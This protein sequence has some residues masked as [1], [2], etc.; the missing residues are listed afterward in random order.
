MTP[1]HPFTV[2]RRA[3]MIAPLA[4]GATAL[5]AR[6]RQATPSPGASP[7]PGDATVFGELDGQPVEMYT[8]S[9]ANGMRITVLTYGGTIQSITVPDKD[10]NA[11]N[12]ALGFDNLD[13]Y[14]A[15]SPYFGCITGRYANRIAR[16]RFTLDGQEY[17]LAIN[18]DPNTL[19]GGEVGFDKRIWTVESADAQSISLTYTSPD[20]EEGYPGT[21]D[22]T[23]T[24]TVT[25]ANE[26]RIDYLA[27]TDATTVLN[28]TNHSY[29]NLAGEGSGTIFDHE[30][31]LNA[32]E[33][34]PVD[35]TLI[36]TGEL[37]PV[38]G[39]PFDFTTAKPIGQ[40]IRDSSDEQILIGR[41]YDHNFV[42]DR[43]DVAEG[44]LA[45]VAQVTEP[46]SGRMMEVHSTEPGV[47]LYTGN[48]LDG[49]FAGTSGMVYRQS[50]A[51]CL[52]TQHFPDS[53]NQ[54]DF[55]STV[56]EPGDEFT[57]TTVYTFS[58]AS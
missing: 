46:E 55:P 48:F 29:F 13:D 16:G 17:E 53:P 19:H 12:V 30:L 8:L 37:A 35:E 40:D 10:G 25:D 50:D 18:N 20:G 54:P 26:L 6:A 4:F 2:S 36:P 28:L 47:Q 14:V 27:T 9:N 41:G 51:F 45:M 49:T 32:P 11:G 23:V 31:M 34:T 1:N 3:M 58:V 42:I 38:A 43:S 44:E 7:M 56:L 24:Y 52:E 57:S 33:F 15:R 21:L 39:T 22:V 5:T